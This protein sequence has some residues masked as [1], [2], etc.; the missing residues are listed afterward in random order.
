MRKIFACVIT[1][2]V[3]CTGG[4]SVETELVGVYTMSSWTQNDTACDAE[5]PS[6]LETETDKAIFVEVGS[7]L[8]Q[9]FLQVVTCVDVP[10]CQ[11]K[12]AEDTIFLGEFAFDGGNDTSGWTGATF[13]GSIAEGQC[14]GLV[15]DFLMTGPTPDTLRVESR[16]RNTRPFPQDSDGF[17]DLAAAKTAAEGQP[18][19]QF[20]VISATFAAVT[21]RSC[22]LEQI[23]RAHV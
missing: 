23:G 15:T 7:L 4:S 18:C 14:S 6:I 5:G 9:E 1:L 8:G 3:A 21:P 19:M 17:C 10:D 22:D 20:E 11:S 16:S 13:G 12:A 2:T